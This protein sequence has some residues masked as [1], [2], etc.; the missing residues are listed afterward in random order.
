MS[1]LTACVSRSELRFHVAAV[2]RLFSLITTAAQIFD[3]V[4]PVNHLPTVL[5]SSVGRLLKMNPQS[6]TTKHSSSTVE[7]IFCLY[8]LHGSAGDRV[9]SLGT[10]VSFEVQQC[11]PG[12]D[13]QSPSESI[14]LSS[15]SCSTKDGFWVLVK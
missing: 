15:F 1:L 11:I 6:P 5:G 3:Q 10:E 13:P 2:S 4:T 14:R 12:T 9:H 8:P 7:P